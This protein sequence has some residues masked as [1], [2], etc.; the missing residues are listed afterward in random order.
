[1]NDIQN[2][3][4]MMDRAETKT[5]ANRY[6][7]LEEKEV[8]R[9]NSGKA[10]DLAWCIGFFGKRGKET[11]GQKFRI[12][13]EDY[14]VIYKLIIY[15]LAHQDEAK[16]LNLK[17][18]KGLLLTGPIGCGKTTLMSLMRF[19]ASNERSF[20]MKACRDI[21][22]EFIQE[23]YEVIGR[24]SKMSFIGQLPR[25]Y[26]FDDLGAEQSLKYYGNECNVL[27]EI[28]LSRYDLF[29]SHKMTT[30]ITTNLSASEIEDVYGSR[31]RSRLREK[32]NVIFFPKTAQDKRN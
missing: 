13:E 16:R 19:A 7:G 2:A 26:C 5:T 9:I 29:V 6:E 21:S 4:S 22:F 10:I 14:E 28:L 20:S 25:C 8:Q 32:T 24:Y 23:G 31:I 15:F 27:S 30:H 11:Y 18:D 17:L 12:Y 1:M 3:Q